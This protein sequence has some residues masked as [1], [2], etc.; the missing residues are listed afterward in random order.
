LIYPLHLAQR[1]RMAFPNAYIDTDEP[2]RQ[3][4]WRK[5]L[6]ILGIVVIACLVVATVIFRL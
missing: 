1:D 6:V 2:P 3:F 4:P 5:V